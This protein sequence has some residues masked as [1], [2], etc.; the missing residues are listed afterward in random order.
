M[1]V[2]LIE[3]VDKLGWLGDVVDVKDGYARN[4]LI[5]YG[6]ATVPSENNLRSI[7]D[8]KERRAKERM[9]KRERMEKV[10]EAVT[11]AEAVIAATTNE[12][13]H[14]FGSVTNVDIAA[15]LREQGFEVEDSVVK[16]D[17]HIK[18]IGIFPEVKLRFAPDLETM[19]KVVVV[20]SNHDIKVEN[21]SSDQVE[22]EPEPQA[23]EAQAEPEE[24]QAENTE[25][26][27]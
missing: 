24:Q 11:G 4:Y 16:L 9:A 14:L 3:D 22:S 25:E 12:Q 27:A 1:K 8:E 13:G 26:Q 5:P 17:E 2:L 19:V 18:E 20:S 6:L 10:S 15:N 21:I 7:A 23:E